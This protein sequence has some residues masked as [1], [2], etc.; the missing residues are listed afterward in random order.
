M[1]APHPFVVGERAEYA[2]RFLG[3]TPGSGSLELTGVDMVRGR[4]AYHFVFSIAANVPLICRIH[5]TFH[6]WV[7][8]AS[9]TSMRFNQDQL[10]CGKTRTRRYEIFGDRRTFKEPDKPEQPSVV[11]ALDDVSFLYFVRTQ[12]LEIGKTYTYARYFKPESN[13]LTLQVLGRERIKVPAGEFNTIVVRP[14]IKTSG[15][16]SEGGQ[17]TVWLSD[18]SLR[19]IVQL[20]TRMARISTV[21]LQLKSYRPSAAPLPPRKP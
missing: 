16:F 20:S 9:L 8:T 18:D 17:A 11:D 6:S 21:T 2:V 10:E 4:H 15:I 13:P 3:F 5:D 14:L 1:G 12:E 7:D 19:T